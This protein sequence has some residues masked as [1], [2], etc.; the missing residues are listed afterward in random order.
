MAATAPANAGRGRSLQGCPGLPPLPRTAAQGNAAIATGRPRLRNACGLRLHTTAAVAAGVD[1]HGPPTIGRLREWYA[2]MHA[3]SAL[4][5]HHRTDRKWSACLSGVALLWLLAGSAHAASVYRC[6]DAHGNLAFQDVPCAAHAR[7]QEVAAVPQPLIG[8]VGERIAD[9]PPARRTAAA[10]PKPVPRRP[11]RTPRPKPD[12]AWEC[13][14]AN[15]EVFYRHTSCPASVAGDGVVRERYVEHRNGTRT[16]TGRGAWGPIPVHGAKVTRSE[17][18][19]RMQS[20]AAAGRDGHLRDQVAS[21]YDR[22]MGRD[23]CNGE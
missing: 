2:A 22:L 13:R 19:R 21:T 10:K 6:V 4:R 8:S 14:A 3:C 15:G 11:M 23:P 1:I 16:R 7:Q 17:A 18:C 9:A 12:A 5:V 20:V